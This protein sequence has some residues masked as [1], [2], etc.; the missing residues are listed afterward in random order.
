MKYFLHNIDQPYKSENIL[1]GPGMVSTTM[2][3]NNWDLGPGVMWSPLCCS[4]IWSETNKSQAHRRWLRYHLPIF[5]DQ[6]LIVTYRYKNLKQV[7]EIDSAIFLKMRYCCNQPG[8]SYPGPLLDRC[9]VE[10]TGWGPLSLLVCRHCFPDVKISSTERNK[11]EYSAPPENIINVVIELT[12]RGQTNTE[13]FQ[14]HFLQS[15]SGRH[16]NINWYRKLTWKL[17]YHGFGPGAD[18]PTGRVFGY[19]DLQITVRWVEPPG[20][21]FLLFLQHKLKGAPQSQLM[22]LRGHSWHGGRNFHVILGARLLTDDGVPVRVARSISLQKSQN[23][24]H[25]SRQLSFN[26]SLLNYSLITENRLMWTFQRNT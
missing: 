7:K 21:L 18:V 3:A 4:F 19:I 17:M 15:Q 23:R 22:V 8:S 26:C 20:P 6:T 1:T 16:N 12:T 5:L 14:L 13:E 11:P 10:Q 2:P 9:W 25:Y 24:K